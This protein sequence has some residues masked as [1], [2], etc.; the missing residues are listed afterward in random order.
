MIAFHDH[1]HNKCDEQSICLICKKVFANERGLSIHESIGCSGSTT[2]EN[3]SKDMYSCGICPRQFK[4]KATL[5]RH[6]KFHTTE[7]RPFQCELCSLNYE[8]KLDLLNHK[9]VQFPNY[10]KELLILSC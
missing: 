1:I 3:I 4:S 6:H 7:G 9:C 5:T 2:C 8:T 10:N